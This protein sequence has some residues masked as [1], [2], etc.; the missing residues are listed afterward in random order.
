[1]SKR[2]KTDHERKQERQKIKRRNAIYLNN[3][4]IMKQRQKMGLEP[5]YYKKNSNGECHMEIWVGDAVNWCTKCNEPPVWVSKIALITS[6]LD[7]NT[8][9]I[10]PGSELPVRKISVD[11]IRFDHRI[12][13]Y[14]KNTF[15]RI[16]N[17][18]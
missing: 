13:H 2:R 9:E 3:E 11:K 10:Y 12:K 17:K 14:P 1:M 5:A 6:I 18:Y 16:P 8:V 7:K 4:N 15:K